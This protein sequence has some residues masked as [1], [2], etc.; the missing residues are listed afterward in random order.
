MKN[1]KNVENNCT[2]GWE[3]RLVC[4]EC[5]M[6]ISGRPLHNSD[7]VLEVNSCSALTTPT[8]DDYYTIRSHDS[9]RGK[10]LYMDAV[11]YIYIYWTKLT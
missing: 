2:K 8:Y 10:V 7:N 6:Y 3:K 4:V 1:S 11:L 9:L 5:Q